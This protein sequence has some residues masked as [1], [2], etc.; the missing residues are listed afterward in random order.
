MNNRDWARCR[1]TGWLKLNQTCCACNKPN[2]DVEFTFRDAE[3]P[4]VFGRCWHWACLPAE[5]KSYQENSESA[6]WAAA[7]EPL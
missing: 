5:L 4:G 1:I 2:A 7:Q 3:I 6:M